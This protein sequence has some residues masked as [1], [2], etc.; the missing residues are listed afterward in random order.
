[1]L[2]VGFGR[3]DITPNMGTEV[4]GYFNVRLMS[5]ILDPLLATAVVFDDGERRAAVVSADTVGFNDH[6]TAY[7]K[8]HIAKA[9][10]LSEDAIF[11]HATHTHTGGLIGDSDVPAE[12][13][14]L[15]E[16]S[17][18]L[19]GRLA[20]AINLAIVDLAPSEKMLYTSGRVED[21]SFVRRFRMKNGDVAT[22]P[23][24]QCPDIDHAL[25]T[26]DEESRLLIIKREG[27]PEIG[28]VNF[29]VHPDVIGGEWVS[30]DY[31]GFV[32]RTY[33]ANIENSLCMYI[34]GTQGDTNHVDV[35]Y[36]QCEK[37]H[38]YGRSEYMGKKIA[39][40]VLSNYSLAEEL[41]GEKVNFATKRITVKYNKGKPEEIE[42]A[43]KLAA[44]YRE[45][46][47]E[48][49]AL[50]HIEPLMR[51]VEM[52]AEACRIERLMNRPDDKELTVS[53]LS[54]GDVVFAGFPG[55]PFTDVGRA[56]RENS[57]FTL[58][59]PVCCVNGYE[60]YFPTEQAFSEGGYETLDAS[61]AEGTAEALVDA[62][63]EVINSL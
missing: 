3:V 56:I 45:K 63:T 20:D 23:G 62:L 61:F 58:T 41:S 31:P 7:A 8:A 19:M 53:A 11:L 6:Y 1:M 44:L 13:F 26:P 43:L 18:W 54:V 22:N 35:R 16:Y 33:E 46:G 30:A 48:T 57:K 21:V 14:S 5:G 9:C 32:R 60:G 34:N 37:S 50:P 59:M 24:W 10:S 28:I 36:P 42:P 38:G 27:K 25:G 51:R 15:N 39:F 12:E 52:V 4:P 29:Q 49:A 47:S 2:K 55:E 40:S 17:T